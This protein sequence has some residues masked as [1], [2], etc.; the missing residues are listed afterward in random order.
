MKKEILIA[1][2]VGLSMG[3]IITFGVYRVKTSITHHPNN[4][5]L[6]T[7]TQEE[8]TATPTLLALHS[9][10]DGTVQTTKELTVTGT[11]TP[12]SMIVLFVNN[13]DFI[14]TTDDSGNFS[15]QVELEE[16]SNVIRVHVLNNESEAVVEERLV[17]VS[18]IFEQEEASN[19]A[20]ATSSAKDNNNI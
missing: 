17:V 3:L 18:D 7:Q 11:T 12:N 10:E 1:I 5:Q 20:D 16:G 19:S 2:L 13:Q 8:A 6:N 4:N 14:S 9:P 15:F